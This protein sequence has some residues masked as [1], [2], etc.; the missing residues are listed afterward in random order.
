[1]LLA[2]CE[3]SLGKVA[4]FVIDE[5]THIRTNIKQKIILT[6]ALRVS[7]AEMRAGLEGEQQEI[8]RQTSNL[9]HYDSGPI[10]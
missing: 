6:V 8:L 1:M 3:T 10:P 9:T 2:D 5:Q 7:G 4:N